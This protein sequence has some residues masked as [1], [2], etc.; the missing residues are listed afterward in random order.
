MCLCPL[1]VYRVIL[2]FLPKKITHHIIITTLSSHSMGF[3]HYVE[4]KQIFYTFRV[5][6]ACLS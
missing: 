2:N 1:R 6:F 4:R 3:K 5:S